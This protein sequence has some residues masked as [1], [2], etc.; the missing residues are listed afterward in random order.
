MD[1]DG[2]F[3]KKLKTMREVEDGGT[4]TQPGSS[5][6]NATGGVFVGGKT[7]V[8]QASRY[9]YFT[10]QLMVRRFNQL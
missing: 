1:N 10:T 2:G 9:N 7:E 4:E 3:K 8:D 6:N 5:S